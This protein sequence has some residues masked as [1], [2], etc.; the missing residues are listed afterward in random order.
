MFNRATSVERRVRGSGDR[1]ALVSM[2]QM[3][4]MVMLLARPWTHTL[5]LRGGIINTL[6]TTKQIKAPRCI[7]VGARE[8]TMHAMQLRKEN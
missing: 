7:S 1:E 3:S 4:L 5:V 2:P 6:I 8:G